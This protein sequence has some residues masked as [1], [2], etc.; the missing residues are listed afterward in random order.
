MSIIY[1]QTVSGAVGTDMQAMQCCEC[2]LVLMQYLHGCISLLLM[3][4]YFSLAKLLSRILVLYKSFVLACR[5]PQIRSKREEY[6]G[7]VSMKS[8]HQI[9]LHIS[10]AQ[11]V[12]YEVQKLWQAPVFAH[13]PKGAP[14]VCMAHQPSALYAA[15]GCQ[16]RHQSTCR[17]ARCSSL[18]PYHLDDRPE[19]HRV[20]EPVRHPQHCHLQE[21]G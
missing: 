21:G 20:A 9:D 13:L 17:C 16:A 15:H 19:G 14:N 18:R 3:S 5:R 11:D 1:F 7:T 10:T 6:Q 12:G 2:G 8:M 4:L